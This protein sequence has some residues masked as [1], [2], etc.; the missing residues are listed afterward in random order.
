MHA[1]LHEVAVGDEKKV[2]IPKVQKLSCSTLDLSQK[3]EKGKKKL[4][5]EVLNTQLLYVDVV[6][7]Y[8]TIVLGV[9]IQL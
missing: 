2:Q 4:L 1:T 9:T 3:A 7:H 6:H 8:H 5:I